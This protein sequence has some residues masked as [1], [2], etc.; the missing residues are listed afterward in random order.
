MISPDVQR[1]AIRTLAKAANPRRI[2]LFGSYARG[3][4]R[5]GKIVHG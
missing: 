4:M 3:D 2:V 5:E 1:T